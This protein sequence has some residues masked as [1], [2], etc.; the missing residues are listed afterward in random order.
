[1]LSN[2]SSALLADSASGL[3]V[4]C[5]VAIVDPR[6]RSMVYVNAGHPPGVLWSRRG[7]RGLRVGGP[8]AG[9]L[10]DACFEEEQL[11][12]GD[13]DLV[14]F[15]SDGITEALDTS[16]D[17]GIEAV[18]TQIE[19]SDSPTPDAVCE[20]LLWA[21]RQGPG[22]SGVD[23]WTDDRTAVA[24][25]VVA[26]DAESARFKIR[27]ATPAELDPAAGVGNNRVDGASEQHPPAVVAAVST[28]RVP[29]DDGHR[30]DR[31]W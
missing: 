18:A 14:V 9:L 15:V 23:G 25:G 16:G 19:Q 13:G 10:R 17:R 31:A 12:F 1:L 29:S 5:I 6:D 7:V 2:L 3:Y 24:F 4:T 22:P 30:P 26:S 28:V 21:A 20:R 11:T 8:P 27:S